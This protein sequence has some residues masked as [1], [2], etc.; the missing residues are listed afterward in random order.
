[1]MEVMTASDRQV[2]DKEKGDGVDG[3]GS[4]KSERR[5]RKTQ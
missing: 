4:E 2:K 1:M 5:K 3:F